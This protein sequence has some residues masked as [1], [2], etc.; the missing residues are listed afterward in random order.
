MRDRVP[1]TCV[2]EV[3]GGHPFDL[4]GDSPECG[5]LLEG[6]FRLEGPLG[7]GG[8]GTVF[9][10]RDEGLDRPVAIKVLWL[11]G[12]R[13]RLRFRR[14]AEVT[15]QLNHPNVIRI[16]GSGEVRGHPYLVYELLEGAE[17]LGKAFAR[18]PL[19]T[20]LD[21]LE[22]VAA[23]VAQAHLQG[24]VHRDLK[25][26]NV[27]VRVGGE[28]VVLDFGLAGLEESRLTQTGHT[29]GTPSCMS[30]EQVRGQKV[31][32][33]CDVWALG[34][35]LYMAVYERHPFLE[36]ARGIHE[37]LAMIHEAQVEIPAGPSAAIRRLLTATLCVEPTRRPRDA[38]EFL[39]KLRAARVRGRSAPPLLLV[40]G[41]C[42][43]LAALGGL[44]ALS[45]RAP[46]SAPS[47]A[48]A[49]L[50]K[51]AS[52]EASIPALPVTRPL[53]DPHFRIEFKGWA[54][55]SKVNF[56]SEE[57]VLYTS[58]D[59][60]AQHWS[61]VG[62]PRALGPTWIL[63]ATKG[64]TRVV[65]LGRRVVV[66]TGK[67][68]WTL[69]LPHTDL[70]PLP[71][72]SFAPSQLVLTAHQGQAYLVAMGGGGVAVG[73]LGG[74]MSSV[75][76]SGRWP[77]EIAVGGGKV[78]IVSH[79]AGQ[80]SWLTLLDLNG[81]PIQA[82][83]LSSPPTT[84]ALSPRGNRILLG[85]REGLLQ[86]GS[87]K[88]N[89]LQEAL[90]EG[91]GGKRIRSAVWAERGERLAAVSQQL[92]TIWDARYPQLPLYKDRLPLGSKADRVQLSPSGA[93]VIVSRNREHLGWRLRRP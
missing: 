79:K 14:E 37:I 34:V 82:W 63:P 61:L 47:G 70:V 3:S 52:P 55:D 30:P 89:A 17:P 90:G 91:H 69:L 26:E 46:E 75:D 86:V 88:P 45:S 40:A 76:L 83:S 10:G 22:Q 1:P 27:L 25:S 62:V 80:G 29:L 32:A 15:A 60:E 4:R 7:V 84:L 13:A 51:Q 77:D 81:D 73:P 54:K 64:P 19:E 93:T 72:L 28:A 21:L 65:T 18:A 58:V 50:N 38:G 16:H 33:T 31:T 85:D 36:E 42:L 41:I 56:V 67:T 49:S 24:V 59:G 23:G 39:L 20:R 35:I 92:I 66:A 8:M 11:K 2:S 53:S 9:R 5:E 48:Q 44:A 68:C 12:E 87:A 71:S 78:G 57:E 43:G 74:I 6:R